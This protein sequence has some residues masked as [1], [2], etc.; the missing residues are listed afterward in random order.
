MFNREVQVQAETLQ[1]I[2]VLTILEVVAVVQ[3]VVVLLLEVA[4]GQVHQVHQEL[5]ADNIREAQIC[6]SL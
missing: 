1:K 3:V 5:V 2:A 6:A 4:V